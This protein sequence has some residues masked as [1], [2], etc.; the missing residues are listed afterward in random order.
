MIRT[1]LFDTVVTVSGTGK[2]DHSPD[3]T[4]TFNILRDDFG[5]HQT[6][7]RETATPEKETA[8]PPCSQPSGHTLPDGSPCLCSHMLTGDVLLGGVCISPVLFH[9]EGKTW[10]GRYLSFVDVH[11]KSDERKM[12]MESD[13]FGRRHLNILRDLPLDLLRIIVEEIET[14]KAGGRTDKYFYHMGAKRWLQE[15]MAAILRMPN[16]GRTELEREMSKLAARDRFTMP[17]WIIPK[18]AV[19]DSEGNYT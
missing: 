15:V 13:G 5:P 17:D 10:V 2:L 3:R 7:G 19:I 8:P 1:H 6:S 4:A 18:D 14:F 11:H 12:C 9:V 16:Q